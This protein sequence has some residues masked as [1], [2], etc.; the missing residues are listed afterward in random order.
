LHHPLQ[1]SLAAR[2]VAHLEAVL[3]Q[4]ALATPYS[5]GTADLPLPPGAPLLLLPLTLAANR[6]SESLQSSL[7]ANPTPGDPPLTLLPPLLEIPALR[8]F[9]L[10]ALEALP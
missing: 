8:Q 5:A 3:C 6:L 2:Y 10:T 7:A 9:L 4:S 1:G